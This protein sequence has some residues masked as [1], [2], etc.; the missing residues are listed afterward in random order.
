MG[1]QCQRDVWGWCVNSLTQKMIPNHGQLCTPPQGAE[2]S[3]QMLR[4]VTVDGVAVGDPSASLSLRVPICETTA[5]LAHLKEPR[6]DWRHAKAWSS[7]PACGGLTLNL[8][9][10]GNSKWRPLAPETLTE[11]R[12]LAGS[13]PHWQA[14]CVKHSANGQWWGGVVGF[15]GCANHTD[16]AGASFLPAILSAT[17]RIPERTLQ[18]SRGPSCQSQHGDRAE[19]STLEPGRP[20]CQACPWHLPPVC[21]FLRPRL[22]TPEMGTT[23]ASQAA[24]CADSKY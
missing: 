10:L 12:A 19:K 21:G 22:L 4:P 2:G 23:A 13:P 20:G 1:S 5:C 9:A 24:V 8:E 14:L 15:P 17:P 3:L 11:S 18:L 7:L 6:G 16:P